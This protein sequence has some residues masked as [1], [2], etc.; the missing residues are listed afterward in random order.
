[1]LLDSISL[2][3]YENT[4]VAKISVGMSQ[5]TVSEVEIL[6]PGDWAND[7]VSSVQE[8]PGVWWHPNMPQFLYKLKH[9]NHVYYYVNTKE[10]YKVQSTK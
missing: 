2:I 7:D 3:T 5:L 1:M 4:I 6:L 8:L 10:M 9:N